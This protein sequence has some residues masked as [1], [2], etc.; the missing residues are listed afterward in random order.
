MLQRELGITLESF[1]SGK[2]QGVDLRYSRPSCGSLIV[3]AKHWRTSGLRKL[4]RELE[5]REFPKA[6]ALS[7]KKYILA[8]SVPLSPKNKEEIVRIFD[9]LILS[10]SDIY[11]C[12][13]RK[14]VLPDILDL[15]QG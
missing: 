6:K 14:Y 4:L 2:D 11:G 1:K 9:G 10:P 8:T 7:P 5:N 15:F 3:Q 13:S 12:P